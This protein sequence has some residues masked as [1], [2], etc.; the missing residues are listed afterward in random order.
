MPRLAVLVFLLGGC[1]H[2]SP[3]ECDAMLDRYLDMTE[4]DDPTLVGMTGEPRAGV[5]AE[6]IAQRRASLAYLEA[7]KRCATEVTP[8]AHA[9]AMKAPTP[10]DWEA[11]VTP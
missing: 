5:R 8:A 11:C 9:C 1:A 7:E 2:P 6:R 10:N 3:A 4:D